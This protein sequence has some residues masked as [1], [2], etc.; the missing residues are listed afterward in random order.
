MG[1]GRD[2][3]GCVGPHRVI[4][5]IDASK[6]VMMGPV[7]KGVK[8]DDVNQAVGCKFDVGQSLELSKRM[9]LFS[10]HVPHL[11]LGKALCEC[12]FSKAWWSVM[13][14]YVMVI[15]YLLILPFAI[16]LMTLVAIFSGR[17]VEFMGIG[18][19]MQI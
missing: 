15:F 6:L 2:N 13:F 16:N 14:L 5:G 8:I 10:P 3:N 19:Y 1:L 12:A 7:K 4:I 18:I 9:N 11:F 17:V